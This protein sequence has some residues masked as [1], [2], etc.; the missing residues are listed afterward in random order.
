MASGSAPAPILEASGLDFGGSGLQFWRFQAPLVGRKGFFLTSR[1][2]LGS[3]FESLWSFFSICPCKLEMR[4]NSPLTRPKWNPAHASFEQPPIVKG[5]CF[6]IGEA[7]V[8]PPPRLS[9]EF[10]IFGLFVDMFLDIR[11]SVKF[12]SFFRKIDGSKHRDFR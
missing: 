4:D 9:M 7:A 12:G 1:G 6:Q 5:S 10:E 3:L 2:W 8:G 11:F